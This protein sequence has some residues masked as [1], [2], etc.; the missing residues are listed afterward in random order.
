MTNIDEAR[1]Y[2]AQDRFATENGAEIQEIGADYAV[3]RLERT[4]RHCN[5][6]GNVMGGT[7]FMLGDCAFAVA[8]NYNRRP[9]VSTT[10]QITFLRPAKGN[11][12]VAK[13]EKIRE[14]RTTVYY[15]V[16]VWD[17]QNN[18]VARMTASGSIVE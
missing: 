18:L 8:S 7:V 17:S 13:A 1:A 16:S 15:E 3:C 11:S 14:G 10:T 9:T 6:L 4:E 2:F 5:A 12:L